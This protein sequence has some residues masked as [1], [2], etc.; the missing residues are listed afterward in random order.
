MM[1]ANRVIGALA[2]AVVVGSALAAHAQQS[3][4]PRVADLIQSG[5]LRVALGLGAPPLAM[6]DPNGGEVRGPALDLAR[7]LAKKIGVKL[8]PVEY[9]RP[10]AILAG[11]KNNEWDVTFLVADPAR[12]EDA[13][14]SPPYMQSDFTYLV[15]AGSS[16]HSVADMDQPGIRIAVPRGDASDLRLTR[17]LKLAELV[18][19]DSIAAA[20]EMVHGGKVDAYAAPRSL[21]LALSNKAPGSR[22]LDDGFA[23]ISFVAMVPKDKGGRIAYVNDFIEEAKATGLVK[24]TIDDANLRGL[25]VAPPGRVN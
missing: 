19:L 2:F 22:V 5:K 13:D 8:E 24:Q 15:P 17:I 12:S 18:R 7:A 23:N 9:P 21:L 6:K 10:G 3:T 20:I 14:F 25:Q 16:K 4:D 1:T 11:V